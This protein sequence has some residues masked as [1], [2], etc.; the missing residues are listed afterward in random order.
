M[1]GYDI[2]SVRFFVSS[3]RD[4]DIGDVCRVGDYSPR[5]L[6]KEFLNCYR[7]AS[8]VAAIERISEAI[9]SPTAPIP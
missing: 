7:H 2:S 5:K 6:L 8:E 1:T 9:Q 4:E 3:Q